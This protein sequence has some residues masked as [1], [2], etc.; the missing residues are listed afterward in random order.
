MAMVEEVKTYLRR[1]EQAPL[2]AF[3]ARAWEEPGQ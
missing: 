2:T 1:I 3:E